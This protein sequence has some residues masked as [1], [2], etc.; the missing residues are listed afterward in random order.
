MNFIPDPLHPA[1][2]H[3]PVVLILLGAIGA[4]G[5]VF[6]R[7]HHVPFFAGVF[8]A[9]GA[10]GAWVAV[11]TGESDGGLM[12]SLSP[13]AESLL[14]EHEDWAERTLVFAAIAAVAALA[15]AA[16]TRFPR[17]ARTTAVVAALTGLVAG[18]AVYET[19]HRGGAL[20]FRHRA[21]VD[22]LIAADPTA[23]E[24]AARP[25]ARAED[26]D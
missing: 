14:E 3:F 4:V 21:G 9:L 6:W 2:V 26:R 11:Q 13:A 25:E 22:A 24:L 19:G 20:V 17:T 12:E 10:V 1:V 18:Y 7:R 23:A 16:L 15:A 8:L 5:A